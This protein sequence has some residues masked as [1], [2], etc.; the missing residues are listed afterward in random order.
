MEVALVGLEFPSKFPIAV[1]W[2]KSLSLHSITIHTDMQGHVGL[3]LFIHLLMVVLSS[4]SMSKVRERVR[5]LRIEKRGPPLRGLVITVT[6]LVGV[7][8]SYFPATITNGITSK[9][10]ACFA[11]G[12]QIITWSGFSKLRW[13][14]IPS[15]QADRNLD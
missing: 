7:L 13:L 2:Q 3:Q 11:F 14:I 9:H 12:M 10:A 5:E 8:E 6:I 1:G 4:F 15:C